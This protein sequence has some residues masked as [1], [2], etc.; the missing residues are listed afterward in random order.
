MR[1]TTT[2]SFAIAAALSLAFGTVQPAAAQNAR[3]A[4]APIAPG[5]VRV[6]NPD[7]MMPKISRTLSTSIGKISRNAAASVPNMLG[8]SVAMPPP[9]APNPFKT[10]GYIPGITPDDI[11]KG[12]NSLPGPDDPMFIDLIEDIPGM[13]NNPGSKND[14]QT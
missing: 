1:I 5:A 9:L 6:I 7:S 2:S 14:P 11:A 4:A 10:S 13:S 8:T 3:I 12:G